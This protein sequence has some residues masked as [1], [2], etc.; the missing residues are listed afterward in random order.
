MELGIAS[1][2]LTFKVF[3]HGGGERVVFL[4][5]CLICMI[6]TTCQVTARQ[7]SAEQKWKQ[8]TFEK[9]WEIRNAPSAY[10]ISLTANK[11]GLFVLIEMPNGTVGLSDKHRYSIQH[12]D[13]NGNYIDEW[14]KFE[15]MVLSRSVETKT[16]PIIVWSLNSKTKKLD[17]IDSRPYL[18]GPKKILSDEVGNVYLID[19][20]GNKIIKFNSNGEIINLWRII[21]TE[22][23]R[24]FRFLGENQGATI[25]NNQLYL[26]TRVMTDQGICI[27]VYIF[28][29]DGK[30]IGKKDLPLFKVQAPYSFSP[31]ARI[32][33][34]AKSE[35]YVNDTAVDKIGNMYFLAGMHKVFKLNKDFKQTLSFDPVIKEGF[36][37]GVM[38]CNPKTG[39]REKY[40]NQVFPS[41]SG[42]FNSQ[43][44]SG[45]GGSRLYDLNGLAF[46]PQDELYI[47]FTGQKPFGEIIAIVYD[48]NGKMIGY[49]KDSVKSHSNWYSKLSDIEKLT[50]PDQTLALTFYRDKIFVGKTILYTSGSVIQKFTQQ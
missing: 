28:T 11:N 14:P 46:S 8:P 40:Y 20:Q 31:L 9:E 45:F 48:T 18:I 30:L 1:P 44:E 50:F 43:K 25:V 19:Y 29:L 16:N 10:I 37:T 26:T 12:Y 32:L 35:E 33:P 34:P 7:N 23:E 39:K 3:P 24:D 38:V 21:N 22:W 36:D 41:G 15:K 42:S 4:I 2:E 47:T 17:N 13:L 49:W 5:A 27:R 6:A